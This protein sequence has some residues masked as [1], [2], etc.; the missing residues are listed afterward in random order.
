MHSSVGHC[1]LIHACF[2]VPSNLPSHLFGPVFRIHPESTH[3]TCS[4]VSILAQGAFRSWLSCG[5][6]LPALSVLCPCFPPCSLLMAA[7]PVLWWKPVAPP[8]DGLAVA[9]SHLPFPHLLYSRTVCPSYTVLFLSVRRDPWLAHSSSWIVPFL[10][11]CLVSLTRVFFYSVTSV[12]P[13]RFPVPQHESL[14]FYSVL[15]CIRMSHQTLT[16][17]VRLLF[18]VV[19]SLRLSWTSAWNTVS[20]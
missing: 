7:A 15:C 12:R 11:W 16:C 14:L 10:N 18:R 17:L 4:V 20:V 19:Y 6:R 1:G 5:P 3:F 8:F 13:Q 2:L 9:C